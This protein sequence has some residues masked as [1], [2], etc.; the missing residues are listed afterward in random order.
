VRWNGGR[1]T[2]KA[3]AVAGRQVTIRL[4]KKAKRA[5]VQAVDD[6]GNLG[7]PVTAKAP[8]KKKAKRPR[9]RRGRPHRGRSGARFTG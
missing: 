1:K 9:T 8:A 3:S 7:V 4:P 6:A 5:T 2:V